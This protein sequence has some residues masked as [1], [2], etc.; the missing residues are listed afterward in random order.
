MISFK[1]YS[2]KLRINFIIHRLRVYLNKLI[3]LAEVESPISGKIRITELGSERSLTIEG[4][5]HS[6]ITTGLNLHEINREYW[7]ELSLIP[8][9]VAEKPDILMLGLGGGS[10]LKLLQARLKPKSITV[11]EHDPVIIELAKK[12][13]F[14]NNISDLKIHN[15]PA[16]RIFEL[17]GRENRKFDLIIDDVY[18]NEKQINFIRQ[19]KL[20]QQFRNLLTP[21]GIIIL[22]RAVDNIKD[23]EKINK[24][25]SDIQTFDVDT[26]VKNIRQRWWNAI[27]YC[28]PK[29]SV[30]SGA[31]K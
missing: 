8:F 9:T 26:V 15:M 24:L 3:I 5:T 21:E 28:H 29:N 16:S 19:L 20:I 27:I 11:I 30:N 1:K 6:F 18:N 2:S 25:I 31:R 7:G 4:A 14:V 12:Y 17:F 23:I 13:F 10:A 22:N